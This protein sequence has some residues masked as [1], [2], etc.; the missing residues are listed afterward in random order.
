MT[1]AARER[2][3]YDPPARADRGWQHLRVTSRPSV[4]LLGTL[5]LLSAGRP[6]APG[7]VARPTGP[8]PTSR[9]VGEL[10]AGLQ[11]ARLVAATPR[12]LLSPRAGR[13]T[14][15]TAGRTTGR[16]AGRT[17]GRTTGRTAGRVVVDVPGWKAPEATGL[18]LRL[19][20]RRLGWD[21]R[22]WGY[23]T[24]AGSPEAD[25]D[26]LTAQVVALAAE[27]GPVAL[28][29]WS[30]GGVISR[31]VARRRPDAVRR[32]VTYGTP[33]VGGPSFTSVAPLYPARTRRRMSEVS[34]RTERDAPL[35][36]PVTALLSRRDGVVAWESC[37][38]RSSTDVE[39]V[40][41][42]SPHL[43]MGIDPDVWRVVADRL[44]R[45]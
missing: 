32:V 43:G 3:P 40:E 20:L 12:L 21:A 30:L 39:H 13:T 44:A 37:V 10:A 16:T 9:Q 11:V 24:N 25:A 31:E 6:L 35:Q 27:H 41:V 17:A 36:V 45:P 5:G 19:Y 38:D 18:P 22:G 2:G 4:G 33:V 1:V 14:G 42:G 8:P 26:R 28:V 15:R 7:R 29:G 23:G 34:A